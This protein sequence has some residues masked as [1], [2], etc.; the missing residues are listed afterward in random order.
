VCGGDEEGSTSKHG[1]KL[2]ELVAQLVTHPNQYTGRYASP[3]K[4]KAGL[5]GAPVTCRI[6]QGGENEKG[7]GEGSTH[8]EKEWCTEG[9]IGIAADRRED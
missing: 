8:D 1:E 5:H 4:P 9:R 3:L 2:V 6:K 7:R